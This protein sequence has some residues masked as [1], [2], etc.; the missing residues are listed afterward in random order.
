MVTA[1]LPLFI[2]ARGHSVSPRIL[3]PGLDPRSWPAARYL[4]ELHTVPEPNSGCWLWTG[5]GHSRGYGHIRFRGRQ[6]FAH[7]LSYAAFNGPIPKGMFI[8]HRCDVRVCVNPD[9]LFAATPDDNIRDRERKGRGAWK[10]GVP[11]RITRRVKSTPPPTIS[12]QQRVELRS[13]PEPNSGC[14]LWVGTT[15]SKGYGVVPVMVPKSGGGSRQKRVPAHRY[16]YEAFRGKISAG[17]FVCHTCDNPPCVNPD[18]LF[19]GTGTENTADRHRKG[20]SRTS[21]GSQRVDAKVTEEQVAEMRQLRK[22]GHR[23]MDI[24]AL[25]G[26]S[27][28]QASLICNGIRWRHVEI[29]A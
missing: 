28:T 20:R 27:T 3:P 23:N 21:R 6:E 12:P 2:A 9:H 18:H 16:S 15:S 26:I 24:A 1:S 19:L 22:L 29:I 7:R 17:L 11:Y 4:T 5:Y 8:C 13:I 14:W 25:F 10:R